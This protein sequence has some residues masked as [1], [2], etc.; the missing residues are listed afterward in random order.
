MRN[1][2]LQDARD[3]KTKY[4]FAAYSTGSQDSDID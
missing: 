1:D 3:I 4:Y 2:N